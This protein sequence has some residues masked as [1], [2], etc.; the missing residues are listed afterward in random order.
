MKTVVDI[1]DTLLHH[2]EA[3]AAE[4]GIPL[5]VFISEALVEKLRVHDVESKPWMKMFGG[6]RDLHDETVRI[7]QII[8]E[9]FE[10][11]EPE[12]WK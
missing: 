6:L 11:I 4:Q 2:A 8:E 9:E 1:P 7:N 3:A 10:Q 5:Q 12:T